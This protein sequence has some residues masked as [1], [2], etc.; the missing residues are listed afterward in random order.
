MDRDCP[1]IVGT[2]PGINVT[3]RE[4]EGQSSR[5]AVE[6]LHS[7]VSV[8]KLLLFVGSASLYLICNT[9]VSHVLKK[10]ENMTP[11]WG[12]NAN[13]EPRDMGSE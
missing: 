1:R 8:G 6:E 4:T 13:K 3:A 2:R 9:N 12:N 10:I 11:N 5:Q 7:M